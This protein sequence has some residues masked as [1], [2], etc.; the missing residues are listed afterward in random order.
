M[1]ESNMLAGSGIGRDC[2]LAFAA[3]GAQ[4]VVFADLDLPSAQTAANSSKALSTNANYRALAIGVDV[5]DRNSVDNMVAQTTAM[6]QRIDYSVNSAGVRQGQQLSTPKLCD[7]TI[8]I[9]SS[10]DYSERW[11]SRSPARCL[12]HR[13]MNLTASGKSTYVAHCIAFKQ[14]ARQ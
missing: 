4:G 14:S 9:N 1:F 12:K 2:A 5:A 7:K 10:A 6:F 8:A 11:A 13:S 3:E